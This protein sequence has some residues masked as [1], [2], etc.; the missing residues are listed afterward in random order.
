MQYSSVLLAAPST[1]SQSKIALTG[2]PIAVYWGVAKR[3]RQRSLKPLFGSSNLPS[4][5]SRL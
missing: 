4:P 5:A 2:S 1:N 3:L